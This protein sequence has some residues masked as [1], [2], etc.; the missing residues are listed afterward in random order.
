MLSRCRLLRETHCR[1]LGLRD[2]VMI[3]KPLAERGVGGDLGVPHAQIRVQGIVAQAVFARAAL[4]QRDSLT[5][6]AIIGEQRRRRSLSVRA[7]QDCRQRHAILDRLV[8][9]LSEMG[10]HRVRGIA[11]QRQPPPRPRCQRFTIVESPAERRLNL[12]QQ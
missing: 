10:K 11:E 2:D 5:A 1:G 6:Q 4:D 8:G 12:A 3:V 7:R 9:S